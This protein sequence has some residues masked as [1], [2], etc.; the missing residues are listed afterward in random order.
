MGGF[1]NYSSHLTYCSLGRESGFH[2]PRDLCTGARC[3]EEAIVEV[4]F[5]L[6]HWSIA[7]KGH[8][9]TRDPQFLEPQ[10][11]K[12][13]ERSTKPVR[14][15]R[16][17]KELNKPGMLTASRNYYNTMASCAGILITGRSR[18]CTRKVVGCGDLECIPSP[19]RWSALLFTLRG[20]LRA[21]SNIVTAC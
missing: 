18:S 1:D 8:H 2:Q 15:N 17:D 16:V 20:T 5:T 19:L 3:L 9:G 13:S 11:D 12:R 4:H 10:T 21:R 6:A 7:G 14:T